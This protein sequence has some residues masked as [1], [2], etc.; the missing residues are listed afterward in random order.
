[1]NQNGEKTAE[2]SYSK[3]AGA[4]QPDNKKVIE[5]YNSWSD[6]YETDLNAGIY[7]GPIICASVCNMLLTN[8]RARILDVGAGTG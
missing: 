4:H 6:Q 8:K 2:V 7:R 1:M 3:N 5:Y